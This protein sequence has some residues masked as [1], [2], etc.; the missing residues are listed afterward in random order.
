[1]KMIHRFMK[2]TNPASILN[3]VSTDLPNWHAKL[4]AEHPTLPD[5][6]EFIGKD[7]PDL[8]TRQRVYTYYIERV[9]N[10]LSQYVPLKKLEACERCSRWCTEFYYYRPKC[11]GI[12]FTL[13]SYDHRALKASLNNSLARK[14]DVN[15]ST[16]PESPEWVPGTLLE[17]D[18]QSPPDSPIS[19]KHMK[20][21]LSS[22]KDVV[23][24]TE[25]VRYIA[26][27]N[28]IHD[29]PRRQSRASSQPSRRRS[30]TRRQSRASSQP[31]R[32]RSST[33]RQSRASSQPDRRRSSTRRQSRA[34]SQPDRRRSS[35]RGSR[36]RSSQANSRT[37]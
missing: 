9:A 29:T 16:T 33:R 10:E 30:S 21:K 25:R 18:V 36:R 28:R 13:E 1:M 8:D 23:V 34:S 2:A 15:I 37:N 14:C 35:T 7:I 12:D 32:R 27:Y 31:D 6:S 5:L 20:V 26:D 19:T 22:G 3:F 17:D 11:Y 4:Q 24:P